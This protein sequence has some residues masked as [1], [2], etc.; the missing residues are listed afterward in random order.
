MKRLDRITNEQT[1]EYFDGIASKHGV[2]AASNA[3][4]YSVIRGLLKDGAEYR[5]VLECGGGGGFYTR[6]LLMD[7]CIVTCVDLSE[8]AL[9][10]NAAQAS[11]MGL[12]DNFSSIHGDFVEKVSLSGKQYD[13]VVFI[14]VLHHFPS[15]E[16]IESAIQA[17]LKACRPGGR[18]VIFEPN[19]SNFLW[20]L[21]LSMVRDKE[22]GRSKWFFEQ[23]LRFTTV[24]NLSQILE[25]QGARFSVQYHYVLPGL[26]LEKE[27]FGAGVLRSIN[28]M[29]ERSFLRRMAFNISFTIDKVA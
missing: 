20:K 17:G 6:R 29:M 24:R 9:Q 8:R 26:L 15:L 14:K 12:S 25:Q 16:A 4:K 18:V 3:D 19:G 5:H 23:N 1:R 27:F 7:G 28:G 22:S 21:V 10:E 13:Q 11:A 2:N